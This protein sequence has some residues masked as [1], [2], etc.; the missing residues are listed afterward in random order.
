MKKSLKAC[1]KIVITMLALSMFVLPASL[2]KDN[3]DTVSVNGVW[4]IGGL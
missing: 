2:A 3:T 1:K 4:L